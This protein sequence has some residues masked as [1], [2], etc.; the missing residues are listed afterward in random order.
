MCDD[1]VS[2]DN[3]GVRKCF[4][5]AQAGPPELKTTLRSG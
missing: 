3:D 4:Y 2:H 1:D 5:C